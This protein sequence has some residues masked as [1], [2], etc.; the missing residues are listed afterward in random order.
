M[1]DVEVDADEESLSAEHQVA[2]R[3]F[4]M[5]LHSTV[6]RQQ[7]TGARNRRSAPPQRECAL[8]SLRASIRTMSS[9]GRIAPLVVIP[10]TLHPGAVEHLV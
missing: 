4:A 3:E 1:G 9:S 5:E 6:F 10:D 7:T 2:D 8:E